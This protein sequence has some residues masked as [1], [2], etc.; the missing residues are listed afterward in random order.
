MIVY[1]KRVE[2]GRDFIG[3]FVGVT[4]ETKNPSPNNCFFD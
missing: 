4:E 3:E 2:A 1:T